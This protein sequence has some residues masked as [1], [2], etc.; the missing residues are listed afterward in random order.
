M[1]YALYKAVCKGNRN[2]LFDTA[3]G[4]GSDNTTDPGPKRDPNNF[5]APIFGNELFTTLASIAAILI[6][7]VVIIAAFRTLKNQI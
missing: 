6:I 3:T 7:I 2:I 4:S 5:L 1:N